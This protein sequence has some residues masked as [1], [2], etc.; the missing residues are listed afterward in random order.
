MFPDCFAL[1]KGCDTVPVV[2]VT[3]CG[4]STRT[5]DGSAVV[6]LREVL[7]QWGRIGCLGFGGPPAHI[8]ML[9]ELCVEK[10]RWLTDEYFEDA[11]ATCNLLPGPASTQLSIL[12]AWSVAG[13][14][15]AI[16]GGLAFILP[17]L[18][19][20]I[21]LAALF[22]ADAPPEW[23]VAA[24]AGASSALTV[25]ALHAGWSLVPASWRRARSRPRWLMYVAAGVA[26]AVFAGP[27]IVVVL[28]T[29]GVVEATVRRL[30]GSSVASLSP[31]V[32]LGMVLATDGARTVVQGSLV[33]TA[34]K[35]GALSYGGGFVIIP[36]MFDDAVTRFGWMSEGQFLDAVVL[37]QVTPGP[38]VHTVSAVGYAASGVPGALVAALVAFAPS[39]L[40]IGAGARHFDR[41]RTNETMRSFLDGTGPAAIGAIAGV[42]VPLMMALSQGWQFALTG[43]AAMSMFVL[44]RGPL[45][46]LVTLGGLGV[47]LAWL[48]LPLPG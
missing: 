48:G 46:T 37:G 32:A 22:L 20:I 25:V 15:G 2:L 43:L 26:A 42:A 21:A 19:A 9:R 24:G 8:A 39:F 7:L 12:C 35:V 5:P 40:F 10:K 3:V 16:V 34:L 11:I 33:W 14:P 41:F 36:L 4:M 18:A 31:A 44:R 13:L 29:C 27:W 28:L 38:V 23:I 45:P 30:G 6:A 1:V 47:V 17:G